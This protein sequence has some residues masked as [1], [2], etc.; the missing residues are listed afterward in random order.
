MKMTRSPLV[1][2]SALGIGVLM[3]VDWHL[4]RPGYD[5]LSFGLAYHWALGVITFAASAWLIL[6]RWPGSKT[7]VSVLVIVLGVMVGQGIEPL[8]EMILFDAQP[9]ADPVRWRVFAEFMVA[10]IVGYGASAAL[11]SRSSKPDAA[12]HLH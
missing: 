6:P 10:G 8:G 1:W 5:Q 12:S 4:G 11:L 9:F 3:H 2:L 7:P